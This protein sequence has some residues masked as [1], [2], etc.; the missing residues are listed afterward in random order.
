[1]LASR[2][3]LVSRSFAVPIS[4]SSPAYSTTKSPLQKLFTAWRKKLFPVCPLI[5]SPWLHGLCSR[6]VQSQYHVESRPSCS[7]RTRCS[8]SRPSLFLPWV[9]VRSSWWGNTPSPCDWSLLPAEACQPC[10]YLMM[11]ELVEKTH[12]LGLWLVYK[13]QLRIKIYVLEINSY[14]LLCHY[15]LKG[16][17]KRIVF[18]RNISWINEKNGIF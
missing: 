8:P 16:R 2:E 13:V 6:L 9:S 7:D 5:N 14:L 11:F 17:R 10:C 18:F 4:M 1:M 15:F 3:Y 12:Y